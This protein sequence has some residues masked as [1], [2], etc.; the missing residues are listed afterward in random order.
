VLAIVAA[1]ADEHPYGHSQPPASASS[2][3]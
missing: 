2:R 1:V 3:A